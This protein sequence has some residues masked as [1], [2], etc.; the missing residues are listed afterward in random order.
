MA[1]ARERFDFVVGGAIIMVFPV[2]A[3]ELAGSITFVGT[4]TV[5]VQFGGFTILT[6]PNF[7]HGGERV[8]LGYGMHA[9]R[10]TEPALS[11]AELPALDLV[12]LSHMHEDHFD[13]IA[14]RELQKNLP[15]VTTRHA[16]SA[17]GQLGFQKTRPLSTWSSV[18]FAKGGRRL[19]VT[20]MPA[21]HAPLALTP[22]FPP[23]MGSMLE[24]MDASERVDLRLYI[25]GDTLFHDRLKLIPLR[26]P[27][28]DIALVHLGGTRLL[29]LLLTMDAGQGIRAVKVVRAGVSIPIHYN[30]YDVF[31]S[32]LDDFRREVERA[33]LEDKVAYLAH[34]DVY[35]F[36]A[37]SKSA[38][39]EASAGL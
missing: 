22:F 10:L 12:V 21:R 27:N 16:A 32:P 15:I 28:I 18:R 31:R 23:G 2:G 24:F 35:E 25:T 20:A 9:R 3:Q 37:R 6:D 26:Y 8:H 11:I 38:T 29:G 30:D 14:A 4:A 17:L 13:R 5:V 33:G 1:N 39:I 36:R 7:L 19:R 34:G